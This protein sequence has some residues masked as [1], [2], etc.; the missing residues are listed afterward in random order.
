MLATD[1]ANY[2]YKFIPIVHVLAIVG[3]ERLLI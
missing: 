2:L 1:G 3:A